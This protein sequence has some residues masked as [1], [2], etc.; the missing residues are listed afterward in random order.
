M[1][2]VDY[3]GQV[4]NGVTFAER[5]IARCVGGRKFYRWRVICP[6]GEEF[7]AVPHEII[8]GGRKCKRHWKPQAKGGALAE[9]GNAALLDMVKIASRQHVAKQLSEMLGQ[10]V[11]KNMVTG[12]LW[13]MGA[14]TPR[15]KKRHQLPF[16]A[17]G[18]CL[19]PLGDPSEDGFAF[20]GEPSRPAGSYCDAHH[21]LTH[22]REG[23]G[24]ER[25]AKPAM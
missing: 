12:R 7:T 5:Y 21:K 4:I 15:P 16:S 3:T 22:L 11:T 8:V 2:A 13:R 24:D 10:K 18:T 20:C 23:P 17:P 19:F 14:T 6:C 25:S 1:T 9:I